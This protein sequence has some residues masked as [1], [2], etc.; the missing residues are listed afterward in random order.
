MQIAKVKL[1]LTF[2]APGGIRDILLSHCPVNPPLPPPPPIPLAVPVRS[3]LPKA[4]REAN[5]KRADAAVEE[6]KIR[7]AA[8]ESHA[9][10]IEENVTI[11]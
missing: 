4:I 1:S 6:E 3:H 9:K 7:A 2:R 11:P 8:E 10:A 5:A